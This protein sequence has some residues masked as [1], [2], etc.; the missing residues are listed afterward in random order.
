MSTNRRKPRKAKP[1]LPAAGRFLV[2]LRRLTERT[3]R[4]DPAGSAGPRV[5]AALDRFMEY[6]ESGAEIPTP[7]APPAEPAVRQEA[8]AS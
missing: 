5:V 6:I 4:H 1:A 8:K 3:T 7:P 2:A